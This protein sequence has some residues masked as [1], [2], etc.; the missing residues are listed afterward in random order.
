MPE[1][2]GKSLTEWKTELAKH[3]FEKHGQAVKFLK[4]TH[5]V[6]HGFAN[7]I[8]TLSKDSDNN[9][10][11]LVAEQYKGKEALLP[12][13]EKL[14]GVMQNFGDDVK[15]VPKKSTVSFVRKIQFALVK[16]A[17]KTRIDLGLKI[18]GQEP[19]G[20]LESSGPFGTMC[21]HRIQLT[22]VE[23]VNDEVSQ[24]LKIAYEGS[25]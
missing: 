11:D 15:V 18:K 3:N 16:P 8:V 13:Y 1:K 10:E 7:T 9:E 4:E 17:T 20:I 12:M 5:G 2:T 22:S 19:S 14:L 6:T 23:E 25:K 21:T 24:W